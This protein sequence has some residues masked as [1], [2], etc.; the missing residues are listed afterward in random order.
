MEQ[1]LAEESSYYVEEG[2]PGKKN[3]SQWHRWE[4]PQKVRRELEVVCGDKSTQRKGEAGEA[5][6]QGVFY[7]RYLH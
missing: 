4:T 7:V 1:E 5:T 6:G 3:S 2:W